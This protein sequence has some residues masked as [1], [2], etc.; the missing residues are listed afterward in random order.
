MFM[1]QVTLVCVVVWMGVPGRDR[2]PRVENHE[3]RAMA[4]LQILSSSHSFSDD[5]I[6]PVHEWG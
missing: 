4:R 6:L 1:I 5:V 3:A 2:S